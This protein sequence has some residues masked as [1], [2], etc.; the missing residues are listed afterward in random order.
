MDSTSV[1]SVY[2]QPCKTSFLYLFIV[3]L[4]KQPSRS[5]SDLVMLNVVNQ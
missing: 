4:N 2:V 5:L 3:N 1:F